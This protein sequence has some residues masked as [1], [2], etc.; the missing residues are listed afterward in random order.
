MSAAEC[1]ERLDD[2]GPATEPLWLESRPR[3]ESWLAA[4]KALP[5]INEVDIPLPTGTLPLPPAFMILDVLCSG[6][7]F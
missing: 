5:P 1:A 2:N 4:Y 6:A 3:G 7:R